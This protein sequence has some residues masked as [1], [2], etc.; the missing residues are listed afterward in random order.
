MSDLFKQFI[1]S[2]GYTEEFLDSIENSEHKDLH[3]IDV[4]CK[5]LNDI[6]KSHKKLIV[7][8]DFDMDGIMSG[9]VGFTGFAELGFEVELFIPKPEFGYGFNKKTIDAMEKEH[10]NFSAVITCDNGISAFEGVDYLKSKGIEVFIT[11][12]HMPQENYPKADVIVD[13]LCREDSY[14]HKA[15]CGAHV[16]WQVLDYYARHYC[17]EEKVRN[18]S[19]LRVFAGIGTVSDVMPV[20]YENR[21]LLKD[22]ITICRL[23]SQLPE[24]DVNV[25]QLKCNIEQDKNFFNT[26][27]F[28]SFPMRSVFEGLGKTICK[29]VFEGKISKVSDIDEEFFGFYLAP[30][31]NS[32]KRLDANIIIAF[33]AFFDEHPETYID[34]LYEL[35]EQRKQLVNEYMLEIEE[36][37]NPYA[38]YIYITNA[39]SGVLGLLATKIMSKTK[40]PCFVVSKSEDSYGYSGSGRSPEWFLA[41]S[42]LTNEGFYIAGHEHAFGCGFTDEKE[43]ESLFAYLDKTISQMDIDKTVYYDYLIDTDKHDYSDCFDFIE[44]SQF[45]KPFGVDFAKPEGLIHLSFS[46]NILAYKIMGSEDQHLKLILSNEIT[47]LLWNQAYLINDI[48]DMVDFNVVGY[49]DVSEF[50]GRTQVNFV[51]NIVD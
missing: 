29:F 46:K 3:N 28:D 44:I 16:M 36:Q 5:K 50:A 39:N 48:L 45:L 15:I 6:Q 20:L 31:F 4:L 51:G 32:L 34:K 9:V 38:P 10:E 8:P 7:L 49:L 23:V 47:V 17:D 40:L 19:L 43:I 1:V 22:A 35:N 18:I 41:N 25:E 21:A 33:G 2:R 42:L 30:M 13:P 26:L 27:G 14:E 11:D 37:D 12:H 24:D